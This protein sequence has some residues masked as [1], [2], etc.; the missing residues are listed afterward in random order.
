MQTVIHPLVFVSLLV[1][2]AMPSVAYK[3]VNLDKNIIVHDTQLTLNGYGVREKWFFDLYVGKL[4]LK[5]KSN[6]AAAIIGSN[7]PQLL[8]LAIISNKITNSKM[9]DAVNEGFKNATGGNTK[10]IQKNIATLMSAF[11]SKIKK[12]D[13]FQFF[14]DSTH[15]TT[16][17]IKNGQEVA[18]IDGM[19]F[20]QALFGIW[21]GD[22]PADKKLKKGLLGL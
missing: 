20:K 9:K 3:G 5:E 22:K 10:P 12:G 14:W 16:R 21:L 17:I 18:A 15:S 13:V 19:A 4:Y 7:Q 11:Q 6:N 1:T 8:E 2:L